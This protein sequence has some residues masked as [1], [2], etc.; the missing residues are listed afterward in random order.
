MMDHTQVKICISLKGLLISTYVQS[1]EST[2]LENNSWNCH[3]LKEIDFARKKN[4][5][6]EQIKTLNL[7]QITT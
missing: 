4:I 1:R 5:I 6:A 7:Y 3:N 2:L